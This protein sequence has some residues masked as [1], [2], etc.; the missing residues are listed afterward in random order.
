SNP[1]EAGRRLGLGLFTVDRFTYVNVPPVLAR[2]Q[3]ALPMPFGPVSEEC[4]IL[5]ATSSTALSRHI[6]FALFESAFC[7]SSASLV[8]RSGT[9]SRSMAV[10]RDAISWSRLWIAWAQ[11]SRWLRRDIAFS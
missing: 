5:A 6:A 11:R 3:Q 9:F 1:A 7:S 8:S 10:N 2:R 4:G